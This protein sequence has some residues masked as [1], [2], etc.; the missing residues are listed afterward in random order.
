MPDAGGSGPVTDPFPP[1]SPAAD[2]NALPEAVLATSSDAVVAIDHR[3]VVTDW[4]RASE[5]LFGFTAAEAIGVRLADLIVPE[6]FREAHLAGLA[7]V[8]DTG[9]SRVCG[10][11]L[12]LLACHRDGHRIAVE[13]TIWASAGADGPRFHAF[14]RDVAA[15][16]AAELVLQRTQARIQRFSA[17]LPGAAVVL[18]REPTASSGYVCSWVGDH[19]PTGWGRPPAGAD[20]DPL[21]DA[22]GLD[23]AGVGLAQRLREA[24]H[25]MHSLDGVFRAARRSDARTRVRGTPVRDVGRLAWELLVLDLGP[26]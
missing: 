21:F 15:L 4:N 7:R 5:E 1:L 14:V 17:L 18:H 20:V 2:A 26:A 3:G 23:G 24:E 13:L 19:W 10:R 11:P 22:V 16:R 6:E 12:S 25:D 9:E 8:V